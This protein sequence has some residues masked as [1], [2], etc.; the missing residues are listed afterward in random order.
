[1]PTR[2]SRSSAA[3]AACSTGTRATASARAAAS[4][5]GSPRA[6]GSGDCPACH[7]Q[8]F[9]RVDPVAIMLVEC[10]GQLLLGPPGPASRRAA[11]RRSP[12]SSSPARRSRKPYG[13]RCSRRPA[14][15]WAR[16]AT[17][18]ASRGRSPR[19]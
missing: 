16:C 13:A 5:P 12:A 7:A 15:A 14:R 11:I 1:M 8:H 19:S 6:A 18:P 2:T 10:D 4:R 9:P 17:S 3:R